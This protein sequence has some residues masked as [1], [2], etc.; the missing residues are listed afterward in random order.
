VS[1]LNEIIDQVWVLIVVVM[2]MNMQV[3]F[4]LLEVGLARFKNTRTILMKNLVDTFVSSIVFW[5]LGYAMSVNA[6]GGFFGSGPFF[7]QPES[8]DYYLKWIIGFSFCNTA[9]TIVSG[10]LAERTFLDTYLFFTVY[11]TAI[12]FP[13][14]SAWVWGGGWLSNLG[15]HDHAGSGVVHLVGGTC[16]LV[17]TAILGPRLGFSQSQKLDKFHHGRAEI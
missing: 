6:Q 12:L 4:I 14:V 11:M 2:I 17:G 5:L 1:H 7:M 9:S 10:S 13:T 3:G 16:G 8:D 15:F